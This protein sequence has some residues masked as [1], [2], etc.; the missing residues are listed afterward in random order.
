[1]P[2]NGDYM[3]PHDN[4]IAGSHVE[5]FF[6]EIAGLP[7]DKDNFRGYHPRAY[8]VNYTRKHFNHRVAE[9]CDILKKSDVTKY[10]LELQIW[11]RD[12]QIEDAKRK[13]SEEAE[14]RLEEIRLQAVGKLTIEE[15]KALGIK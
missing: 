15:R 1:M 14:A 12:H 8:G 7:F 11:W 10:S 6:D 9:L 5:T 2:C 3:N 13:A 4:E